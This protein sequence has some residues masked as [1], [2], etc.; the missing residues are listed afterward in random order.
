MPHC[1]AFDLSLQCL[2]M[3]LYEVPD[4]IGLTS[5]QTRRCRQETGV[6]YKKISSVSLCLISK[7]FTDSEIIGL[8]QSQFENRV[9][10]NPGLGGMGS[11][12]SLH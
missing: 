5:L 7:T 8:I 3:T 9:P 12:A 6:W 1:L 2:P 4:K 10:L 11:V